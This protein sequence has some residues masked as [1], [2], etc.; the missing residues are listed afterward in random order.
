MEDVCASTFELT[1][2]SGAILPYVATVNSDAYR[3]ASGGYAGR[4]PGQQNNFVN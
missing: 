3:M 1:K 4:T 2:L